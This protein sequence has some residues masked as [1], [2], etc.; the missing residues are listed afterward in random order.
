V[1]SDCDLSQLTPVSHNI[2]T[3]LTPCCTSVN[4]NQMVSQLQAIMNQLETVQS[5]TTAYPKAQELQ[6]LGQKKLNQLLPK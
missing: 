6:Q 5:G 3:L 1:R 4:R 2:G